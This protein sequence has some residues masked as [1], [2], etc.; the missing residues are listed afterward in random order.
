VRKEEAVK[1]HFRLSSVAQSIIQRAPAGES[2]SERY[3]FAEGKTT[4]GQ[5]CRAIGREILRSLLELSK[6]YFL[7]GKSCE[8]VFELLMPA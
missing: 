4:F 7:E 3:Q 2:K 1:R 5:K 6:R 8:Q